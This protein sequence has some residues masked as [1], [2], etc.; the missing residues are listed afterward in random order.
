MISERPVPP[1]DAPLP[2]PAAVA[3]A[4]HTGALEHFPRA[5]VVS[6]IPFNLQAGGGVTMGNLFRGWPFDALAQVYTGNQ[7]HDETVCSNY[8]YL[9]ARDARTAVVELLLARFWDY[10]PTAQLAQVVGRLPQIADVLAWC[11]A[12][13][14]DVVYARPMDEPT[15]YWWLPRVLK[16]LLGIP[17][18]THIMD[19]WPARYAGRQRREDRLFFKPMLAYHLQRLFADAAINAGISPEMCRAYT[20]RYGA[21]FLQLHNCIDAAYWRE[22]HKTYPWQTEFTLVYVGAVTEDKE[23]QSLRDIRDVVMELSA[24]GYPLTFKLYSSPT[25]E[26][27]IRTKLALPPLITYAGYVHPDELPTMLSEADLLIL[28][29]NFDE[30]SLMYVGYSLQTKVPEYMASGTPTLVYGPRSS[31]N[32]RYA[33][34]AGWGIVIDTPDKARIRHTLI[35]LMRDAHARQSLGQHARELAFQNHDAAVIRPRFR[36]LLADI[37]A[38]NP[39]DMP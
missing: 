4:A 14:F 21:C 2:I 24:Q 13:Q 1:G 10:L 15:I 34:E 33:L 32:V 6:P 20:H 22:T 31:P 5:L 28:P 38:H 39:I 17:Y 36:R 29:I 12:F 16:R 37:A 8:Y 26:A 18:I 9:P 35:D 19:D 23:L 25:W 7:S 30:R 27:T 11:R 3:P